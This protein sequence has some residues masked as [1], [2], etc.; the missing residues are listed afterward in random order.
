VECKV[1]KKMTRNKNTKE[2]EKKNIYSQKE[3]LVVRALRGSHGEVYT[4][5]T[6]RGR[7]SYRIKISFRLDTFQQL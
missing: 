1:E 6:L 3:L 7:K 2:Q 5:L 4:K